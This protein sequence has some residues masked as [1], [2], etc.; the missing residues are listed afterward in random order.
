M[1]T[2][3]TLTTMTTLGSYTATLGAIGTVLLINLLIAKELSD[4]H[5]GVRSQRLAR[6]IM[7]AITPLLFAFLMIVAV[8]VV[9]VL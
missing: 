8:K 1:T 5:G 7:I 9:E 6:N 2:L 3:T 4:S